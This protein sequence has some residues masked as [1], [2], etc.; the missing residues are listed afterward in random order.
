MI[1]LLRGNVKNLKKENVL[2]A[3]LGF[4]IFGSVL[5]STSPNDIDMI[6]V[7]KKD[8]ISISEILHLR[9]EL[10]CSF[11]NEHKIALDISLL[12]EEE[13]KSLNF[14]QSEKAISLL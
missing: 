4:Y 12:T 10:S 11:F 7:Y 14:I 5:Y 1:T 6:I 3:N 2:Y 9:S 13:E 8:Q